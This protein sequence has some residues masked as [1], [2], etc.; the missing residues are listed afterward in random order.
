MPPFIQKTVYSDPRV[1]Y[2]NYA[3]DLR[4]RIIN[5]VAEMERM[6][7]SYIADHFCHYRKRGIELIEVI[8]STKHLTYQ[9]KAEILRFIL[10]RRGDATTQEAKKIW[11]IL[12][13]KKNF[14]TMN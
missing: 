14:M 10:E 2:L 7:D 9:S 12:M 6:I 13:E 4:G 8:I 5:S 1:D 3:A 11:Q